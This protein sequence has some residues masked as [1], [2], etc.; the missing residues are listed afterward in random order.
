M[1]ANFKEKKINQNHTTP[2][3]DGHKGWEVADLLHLLEKVKEG[4]EARACSLAG[5]GDAKVSCALCVQMQDT[6]SP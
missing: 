2:M 3:S 5:A 1:L 6:V 4:S